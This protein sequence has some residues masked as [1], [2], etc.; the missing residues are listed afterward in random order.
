MKSNHSLL[1]ERDSILRMQ[2]LVKKMAWNMLNES[3]T[4]TMLKCNKYMK[5]ISDIGEWLETIFLANN[6]IKEIS[7]DTSLNCPHLSTLL[8]FDNSIGYILECFFTYMNS[9]TTVGLSQKQNLTR[10]PHSLSNVRSLTFL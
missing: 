9:L 8:L 5:N 6:S 1:L 7:E 3:D 4:N 2:S 10:L